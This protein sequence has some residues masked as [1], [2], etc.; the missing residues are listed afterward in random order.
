MIASPVP[1][2]LASPGKAAFLRIVLKKTAP[3]LPAGTLLAD[4]CI[5]SP[6]GGKEFVNASAQNRG[7]YFDCVRI[8]IPADRKH[9]YD[10]YD[11]VSFMEGCTASPSTN[12]HDQ[13]VNAKF[14]K[15]R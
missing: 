10:I 2:F 9:A 7:G 15:N 1:R 11:K 5:P 13:K 12:R 8:L 3:G 6:G 14:L 4:F